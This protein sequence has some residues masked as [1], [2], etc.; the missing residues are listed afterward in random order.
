MNKK[1]E[2]KPVNKIKRLLRRLK[3]PRYLHHF[4]PKIYHRRELIESG[5][6]ALKRKY[7]ISVSS[8][9]ARMIRAELYL[10]LNCHN[11]FLKIIE[12]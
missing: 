12:I 7:G 8:R 10:R 6:S 4:G 9:S 5:N 1:R 11:L 3:A 2:V